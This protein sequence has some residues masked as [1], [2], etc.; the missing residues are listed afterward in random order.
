[1]AVFSLP[2]RAQTDQLS[3]NAKISSAL[4]THNLEGVWSGR[5]GTVGGTNINKDTAPMLPW[6]QAKFDYNTVELKKGGSLTRDP[7]FHCDPTGVPRVYSTGLHPFEIVQTPNRIFLFYESNHIWRTVWMDGRP[8]PKDTGE[9][10]WMGYSVGRWDG[11]DLVIETAGFNDKTWLDAAGSPHSDALRVVERFRRV[12]RDNLQLEVTIEDPK[13]YQRPW[14][15]MGAF[16]LKPTWEIGEA[17]CV[18]GDSEKFV[19]S[20]LNPTRNR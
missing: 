8:L 17:F 10:L 7:T 1:L 11:D 14:K 19:K 3:E 6:A 12:D 5:L 15:M 20:I 13:A 4:P 9:P 18:A 2:A 16:K